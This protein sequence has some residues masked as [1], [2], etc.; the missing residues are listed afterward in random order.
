M[1]SAVQTDGAQRFPVVTAIATGI[2]AVAAVA[3]YAIPAMIPALQ[4]APDSQWWRLLTSLLVQTL[5]W[6]QVVT[7]LVTLAIIGAVAERLLGRGR[8]LALFA[9][10]TAGGQLAAYAW[11][12]PGGGDSI[13]I[14]GLAAGV[15]VTL[16]VRPSAGT[17]F[18]AQAVV[19]YIAALTGWGFSGVRAAV[20][21]CVAAGL[22][23]TGL[24]RAGVASAD[25]I[26]LTGCVVS[27]LALVIF[28]QD[29]HGASL[30]AGMLFMGVLAA[31]RL[32]RAAGPSSDSRLPL[33]TR[34]FD[35]RG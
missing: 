5:G 30:T 22:C 23:M 35:Q 4:R 24:R 11:H 13:A 20:L 27:A 14:C 31:G 19:Y 7:N 12:D 10:G 34:F 15:V 3:Q 28:E 8:W 26:A 33:A 21:A 1:A 17:V 9:A 32:P 25:R 18:A 16:L 29:L 2:A 6:Y